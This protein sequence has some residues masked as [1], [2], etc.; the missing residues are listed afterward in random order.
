MAHKQNIR[1]LVFCGLCSLVATAMIAKI[2]VYRIDTALTSFLTDHTIVDNATSTAIPTTATE[3][4]TAIPTTP[5]NHSTSNPSHEQNTIDHLNDD[6]LSIIMFTTPRHDPITSQYIQYVSQSLDSYRQN[7]N[8]LFS[9]NMTSW[10]VEFCLFNMRPQHQLHHKVIDDL[11]TEYSN[12]TQYQF[13]FVDILPNYS[14]FNNNTINEHIFNNSLNMTLKSNMSEFDIFLIHN[15]IQNWD[16]MAV[17]NYI[18]NHYDLYS[19]YLM[20]VEDDCLLCDDTSL[21]KILIS[22]NNINNDFSVYNVGFGQNGVIIHKRDIDRLIAAISE[23]LYT[24]PIDH[25]TGRIWSQSMWDK[26]ER[27]AFIGK[28]Y[29]YHIGAVSAIITKMRKEVD[30]RTRKQLISKFCSKQRDNTFKAQ[31]HKK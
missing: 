18:D 23:Q 26:Y 5:P 9:I 31:S 29:F 7:F 30:T 21:S 22:L 16:F 11:K 20:F 24:L 10:K 8:H 15:S 1:T 19:K 6:S 28:C 27:Q 2:M 3:T 17:L 13:N 25:I 12:L 14:D 4:P